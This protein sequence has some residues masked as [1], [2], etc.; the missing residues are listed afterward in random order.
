[1][2]FDKI[3]K[4]YSLFFNNQRGNYKRALERINSNLMLNQ[5]ENVIDIGCGT[6]ALCSVLK[7]LGLNVTGI[8]PSEK[9]INIAKKKNNGRE[10]SFL[11]GNVLDRLPFSDKYFDLSIASYVAHGL[12]EKDRISMY[13]EMKRISRYYVLIYDYNQKRSL[14][15]D[16]A[17]K[18][19]GGDYF[20]F[21]YKVGKEMR[22]NFSEVSV[23]QTD[24]RAACYIGKI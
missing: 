18:A 9:M 13:T 14:I 17:E 12:S 6:G 4:I 2:D 23:V 1:M 3:A 15:T 21:I 16:I 22:E 11:K 19:E 20:N 7:D 8:D 24:K 5:Y 10:I